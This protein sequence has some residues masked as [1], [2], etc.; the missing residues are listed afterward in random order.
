[1]P[2][3]MILTR[4]G[5][6]N[7]IRPSN[8]LTKSPH[9]SH[10]RLTHNSIKELYSPHEN[11]TVTLPDGRTLGFA[12]YGSTNG[13]PL[14]FFHGFPSSRIEA[15]DLDELGKRLNVRILSMDRPGIGLSSFHPT[16]QISDWAFDV[17]T[18]AKQLNIP[19]YAIVGGS[20]GSPYALACARHI[21]GEEIIG[22]GVLAGVGPYLEVGTK[23]MTFL[24]RLGLNVVLRSPG[25]F[26]R[27]MAG[28]SSKKA[29]DP[30]P[31]VFERLLVKQLKALPASDQK[32]VLNPPTLKA[33]V[34][35]MR[36]HF[37]N[38]PDGYVREAQLLGKPWG[39]ELEQVPIEG[40]WF[41]YGSE[42]RNT[43][44][45]Q[46]KWMAERVPRSVYKEF[47]GA[48]HFTIAGLYGEEIFQDVLG[49]R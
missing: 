31:E 39:F 34:G 22:L 3:N 10:H 47:K 9:R 2:S 40:V 7:R 38:G 48:S 11:Q 17:R 20:G 37:R 45:G 15:S 24:G 12:E 46:G 44:P 33:V 29:Q 25:W 43:P 28:S 41:W 42:D 4:L 21:P 35:G 18:F 27:S 1:M 49:L 32:E 16:R 36:E 13:I 30:D 8:S 6:P 19:R 26:V 14:L 23:G 5:Q